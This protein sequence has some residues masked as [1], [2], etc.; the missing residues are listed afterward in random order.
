VTQTGGNFILTNATIGGNVQ[1][2]GGS[3]A[4]G[5]GATVNGNVQGTNLPA[6]P[7][8]V[9]LCGSQVRGDV[10][11]T[12]NQ[13]P[14]AIG[15]S[16]PSCA[17]NTIRGNLQAVNDASTTTID[18]NTVGGNLQVD[19]GTAPTEI[20][21]NTISGNLQCENN[22]M[23]AACGNTARGQKQ[24]QC[25]PPAGSANAC[26]LASLSPAAFIAA[27]PRDVYL[28]NNDTNDNIY[29]L[30]SSPNGVALGGTPDAGS[31]EAVSGYRI[32]ISATPCAASG[33]FDINQYLAAADPYSQV[34]SITATPI[35]GVPG[36]VV[37]FIQE[38]N[39]GHPDAIV[40]HNGY[41]Y[42][43]VYVSTDGI[44]GF[45]DQPGLNDFA[46]VLQMFRFP[47]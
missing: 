13:A 14:I 31:S 11:F 40:Y 3:F 15:S 20:D 23:I 19:N 38:E 34:G 2:T 25:S 35:G 47:Q 24:G 5:P 42:E 18:G 10:Q 37:T 43:I 21:G 16:Q 33:A 6:R 26:V 30:D 46:Q 1:A 28:T 4:I 39:A 44:P 36:Y 7:S 8:Q 27:Y 32:V 45:S 17:G 9:S 22:A 29:Y 12:N 41:V